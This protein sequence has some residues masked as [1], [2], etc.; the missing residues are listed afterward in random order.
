MWGINKLKN[1]GVMA[2][3]ILGALL[4]GQAVCFGGT[5]EWID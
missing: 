5:V 4:F 3:A 1:T 2:V